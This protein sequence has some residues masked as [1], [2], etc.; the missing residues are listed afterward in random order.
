MMS[1][2][3]SEQN[4]KEQLRNLLAN[5]PKS[6][7]RAQQLEEKQHQVAVDRCSTMLENDK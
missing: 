1:L 2:S 3:K 6:H 7:T 4:N 5:I